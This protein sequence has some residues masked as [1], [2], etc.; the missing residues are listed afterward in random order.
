MNL[1]LSLSPL[2]SSLEFSD[3]VSAVIPVAGSTD[4]LVALL[5]RKICIVDRNNGTICKH[6][7]H[8]LNRMSYLTGF[9]C[10]GSVIRVL[11]TVQE[12]KPKNRFNDAKCDSSGR[13][14]CGTMGFEEVP[15]ELPPNQGRLFSYSG[16]QAENRK[17]AKV[18]V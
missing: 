4:Q 15:G 12:D 3:T 17:A 14:W 5:G 9:L 7:Y 10:A 2:E 1:S 16:G 13:L 11:A 6:C 8:L 18:L